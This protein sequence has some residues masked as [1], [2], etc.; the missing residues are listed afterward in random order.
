M[1]CGRSHAAQ[2]L[3]R[4]RQY[5]PKQFA[6]TSYLRSMRL[7][8]DHGSGPVHT[9][10][11]TQS[12]ALGSFVPQI[13]YLGISYPKL[14]GTCTGSRHVMSSPYVLSVRLSVLCLTTE[15]G[16]NHF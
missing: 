1:T 14:N 9:G 5:N 11:G 3:I 2:H 16:I 12:T 8:T 6:P 13:V 7:L 10:T 4:Y 15:L